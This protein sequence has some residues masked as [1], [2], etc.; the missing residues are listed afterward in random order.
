MPHARTRLRALAVAVL[1]I[2]ISG[3]SAT[4]AHAEPSKAELTKKIDKAS[5]QLEDVVESYNK[6][7]ISLKK[8]KADEKQLIASLE[9][10]KVA[11]V[12]AS[13]QMKSIASSAY[14][15]GNVGTMNVMLE[16][17][18]NL[19]ERMSILEQISRSRS[20]DVQKYT[21][22]TQTFADRQTALKATQDRQA[23]ELKELSDRKKK[24]EGDLKK[25]FAMR[26]AAFGSATETGSRYTGPIPNIAGSAGKAVTFAF[27]AIGVMYDYGADGPNGYDCSGLTSAA[28][29]AAGKS[30]P[31]NAAAQYSATARISKSDLKAGDLVFYRSLGHVGIY[32]G[33]G[34]IIDASR[35]GQPV[36]KRSINIMTPYGYGR[37]T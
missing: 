13:A 3:T 34:Q 4:A 33:G 32:V 17:S 10:A 31:H 23:A 30:L 1:A 7:K 28:W 29:R 15:T 19:M 21:E 27:N 37:V 16:G 25:L 24:I 6:M 18:D 2:A 9:P 26:T 36:K 11:L 12:A 22:T 14:K 20:R 8:T 35:A 5:D